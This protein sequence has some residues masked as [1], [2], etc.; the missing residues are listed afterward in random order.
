MIG[1]ENQQATSNHNFY[2]RRESSETI[3]QTPYSNISK[4][5]EDIVHAA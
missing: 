5:D 3:R 4:K 1:A 2:G